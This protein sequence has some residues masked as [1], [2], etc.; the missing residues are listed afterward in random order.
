MSEDINNNLDYTAEYEQSESSKAQDAFEQESADFYRDLEAEAIENQELQ[1]QAEEEEKRRRPLTY[2]I[3]MVGGVVE[4]LDNVALGVGDFAFDAVGLVPWLKPVDQWWDKNSYRS[5]HPAHKMIRDASSVI[6]PSMVGGTALVGSVKAATAAMTI[7]K[8][9]HILGSVGA[10]A[11][12]DTAVSMISSHSKTDDNLAGTLNE[13]LGWQIPWGTLPSDS[14]DIRWRKNV[15]ESAGLSAGVELLGAAFTFARKAKLLPRDAGAAEAIVKR[16][17]QLSLFDDP[18]SAAVEPRRAAREAAQDDELLEALK[19]DPEGLEYNAFV[20]DL[21]EDAAG[22]AVNDLEADP[23]K[24]KLDHTEIQ[25]NVN[26]LNGR[27]APVADEAFQRKFAAALNSNERAKQLDQLFAAIS[28]NFDAIVNV[29]GKDIQIGAEQMNRA[30]DN[31]TSA[32]HGKDLSLREFEMIVDDMKSTVFNSNTFLDEE[33]WTIASKAFKNAYDRVF[34]PNQMRASAMLTQQAADAVTDAATGAMMLGDTVDN[35]RQFE[36]MFKKLN[37]LGTEVKA[38][39]YIVSKA[40]EYKKLKATGDS[41]A[42]IKWMDRQAGDFDDYLKAIKHNNGILERELTRIAKEQ[43]SYLKAFKE[44]YDATNGS[45]D[46]LEKMH[47]FTEKHIGFLKKG[48]IDQDPS[49][50]SMVVKGLHGVKINSVL[51]GLSAG[52]AAICNTTLKVAKPIAVLAGAK[53]SGE[54]GVYKRAL[55]TYGGIRENIMRAFKV[56]RNEWNLATRFPEEAMMRGRADLRQAQMNKMEYMDTTAEAWEKEGEFGKVAMWKLAKSLTWFTKQWFTKYGTNALYAIDGFTNSFMA[57]GMSRARAYDDLFAKTN[58]AFS[59]EAFRDLQRTIYDQAF[60]S[61]G[62]LRDEAAKFASQEIALNLDNGVVKS[63]EKFMEHTPAAKALF[64]FPRTGVNGFEVGWSFSP[65]SNLGPAMTKARNVLGAKT[66]QPKLAALAEH[67]L[68]TMRDPDMAFATLKS[69]Y[70]GRQLMGSGIVLGVGMYAMDGNITGS[71]P[72][73]D[74]E[75]RRMINEGW[76]PFSIRNPI[77]G[78]WRSYQGFEP[79]ATLMGLTADVVYQ[80]HRVDQAVTE[81][82]LRKIGHSIT[83]NMTNDTFLSGFEPLA[84]LISGD[85]G[86]WTRFWAGQANMQ[87]PWKGPRDILNNVIAPQLRDV[88]ND[89]GAYMK[90]A[91]RFL[92]SGDESLPKMVDVYTGKPIRDYEVFTRATNAFMPIFKSNGGMEPWRQWLLSTGWDGLN[93]IRRDRNTGLPLSPEDRQYINNWIGMNFSLGPQIQQLMTEGDGYWDKFM[94]EYV[95]RRGLRDQRDY[96]LKKTLLYKRLDEIHNRAFEAGWDALDAHR[97]QNYS[98]IGREIKNRDREL[99]RGDLKGA[100]K[101]QRRVEQLLQ[102][103]RNK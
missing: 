42:I 10:W 58:G 24:A 73:D 95:Q 77:T 40:K 102:Q 39:E 17:E 59:D 38:N 75:R 72:Q 4:T 5:K 65:L 101:T 81:D 44:V 90:N 87:I 93:K 67:G 25:Q 36:I 1:K 57:S 7:P 43:P 3:P 69:E 11:G 96:P 89:F 80:S 49:V 19:A 32:I 83:M 76:K 33:Q 100:Q 48:I 82:L 85:P 34:D 15:Y 98:T 97:D 50:P 31:L 6:V 91:N 74:A 47:K 52:T 63:F 23:L 13:W 62:V 92:F 66:S 99:G 68:D 79:F 61:Q 56:M 21:G 71:G 14:P 60:D 20:N 29:N 94:K 26:T 88:E 8:Y 51:S 53:L 16:D 64:M 35:S 28:P 2:N 70:I 84:G 30:V 27:A 103:T 37:L 9:A 18:V 22:K 54:P 12:V 46:T 86:A 55:Y 45:V 78:E 41:S